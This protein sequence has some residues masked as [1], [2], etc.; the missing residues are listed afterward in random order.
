MVIK[1]CSQKKGVDYDEVY[2][3]VARLSTVR[4]LL[5]LI[6]NKDLYTRQI[7]VRNASL[8]G[9]MKEEIYM[10][11]PLGFEE[12]ANKVCRL[13]KSLYGLKQVPKI[14]N[15]RFNEIMIKQGFLASEYDW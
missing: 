1:G 6:I 3:P 11:Q 7:D 12:S 5:S 13:N 4:T 15:E 10:K 9:N 2:A 8:H 14:W